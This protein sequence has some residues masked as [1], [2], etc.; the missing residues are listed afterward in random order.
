[1]QPLD[2]FGDGTRIPM[3]VVSPYSIGGRVSHTY[4]DH[5]S[6]LKFI[7]KNWSLSTINE[8]QPRQSAKPDPMG[9]PLCPEFTGNR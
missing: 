4:T 1:M 5:V 8:P 2:F 7:E 6:T 3:I 9:R